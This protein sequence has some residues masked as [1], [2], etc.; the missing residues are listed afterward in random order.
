MEDLSNPMARKYTTQLR[1]LGDVSFG[2]LNASKDTQLLRYSNSERKFILQT[3]DSA[4]AGITT[5]PNSFVSRVQEEIIT[6]NIQ[7]GGVDGGSF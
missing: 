2:N 1:N 5:F 4:L 7:F 3:P 6:D